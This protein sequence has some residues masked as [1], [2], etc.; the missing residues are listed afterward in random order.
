[1]LSVENIIYYIT[2]IFTA[3]IS[4]FVGWPKKFSVSNQKNYISAADSALSTIQWRD[5]MD[6]EE[7]YT[8]NVEVGDSVCFH[9]LLIFMGSRQY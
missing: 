1:M 4:V 2:F 3:D 8:F 7:K 6:I 5:T 9:P